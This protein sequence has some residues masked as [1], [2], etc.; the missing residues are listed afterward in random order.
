MRLVNLSEND[1]RLDKVEFDDIPSIVYHITDYTGF[2]YSI[3]N[4]SLVSLRQSGV[5]F[6]TNPDLLSIG[7]R[8]HYVFRLG[9]SKNALIDHDMYRYK[10][11]FQYV[12]SGNTDV[13]EYREDEI[14][15]T[16]TAVGDILE[17]LEELTLLV[18]VFSRSF[19]QWMF[20]NNKNGSESF[21]DAKKSGS[22]RAVKYLELI[23]D[24]DIPIYYQNLDT[25]R[26]LKQ[27]E[28]SFIHDCFKLARNNAPFSKALTWLAKKYPNIKNH[29][30]GN[31][32][33]D[34]IKREK[35]LP[36]VV[37][38]FNAMSEIPKSK[39]DPNKTREFVSQILDKIGYGHNAKAHVMSVLDKYNLFHPVVE[40]VSWFSMFR[41][42]FSYSLEE[43]DM[44]AKIMYE[45]HNY[46]MEQFV[47]DEWVR[48]SSHVKSMMSP[49]IGSGIHETLTN[50]TV[51]GSNGVLDD[52]DLRLITSK[53]YNDRI[54]KAFSKT[55]FP[56]DVYVV[57]MDVDERDWTID[58]YDYTGRIDVTEARKLIPDFV[59][60]P[61]SI[62]IILTNNFADSKQPL[63][64][65]I[66][67]HRFAHAMESAYSNRNTNKHRDSRFYSILSN[68]A[69]RLMDVY[70]KHGFRVYGEDRY[71][72]LIAGM[73]TKSA[74]N[75]DPLLDQGEY[76]HELLTQFIINGMIRLS[77]NHVIAPS[78]P[79]ENFRHDMITEFK[80]VQKQL[81]KEA[82]NDLSRA[83]GDIF[84]L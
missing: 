34:T 37:K 84:V 26:L 82:A 70:R 54:Q 66:I 42:L 58:Y 8:D 44:T 4:D 50:F 14:R 69:E 9:L 17:N 10:S 52:Q 43:F 56:F 11:T 57:N 33:Y 15:T 16:D 13:G 40:P 19:V 49:T 63:T 41:D 7:G 71:I 65:W 18:S 45:R 2:A 80:N 39:I 64:P 76:G 5:S 20:Y 73:T 29:I 61:N 53:S 51:T 75:K 77:S 25:K 48:R 27:N 35:H 60:D 59:H 24:H 32:D 67:A 47:K 12:G 38:F 74:R 6:T 1:I 28:I 36:E 22:D 78:Y 62:T 55:P 3:E 46:S 83:I 21:L 79:D 81:N 72:E 30:T 68:A 23:M 31:V